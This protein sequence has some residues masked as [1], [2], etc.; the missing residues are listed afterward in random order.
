[1]SDLHIGLVNSIFTI[2]GLFGALL[3]GY[4]AATFGRLRSMR[5][6][7][8]LFILGP[9]A[10]ALAPN[11]IVM[12][13]GRFVSGL[14]AGAALV[15]VPIYIS[16][17]APPSKKG[18]FG[19]FTQ[20]ATNVGIF[21]A[22]LLGLFLSRGQLWRI[23]LAVGG[24]FG[25]LQLGGLSLAV[26]SP[27]W[28]AEHGQASQAKKDLRKIRG[29]EYDVTSEVNGWHLET[30]D[31]REEEG[32]AL[33]QGEDVNTVQNEQ[34]RKR[35]VA[36]KETLGIFQVILH[37]QY[38]R[39]IFAVMMVMIAQQFCGINSIVIYGVTLLS[40]L[41]AASA[42]LLNVFVAIINLAVT[43][44]C[45][46]LIDK[47]GR[48]A[49]LLMS[50]VGMGSTSLL[51]AIAIIKSVPALSVIAVL[52]FVAS[53]GLGL[54]PVPFILSSELV[55]P[56]AVGA[57]QSWALAAN[58]ISTFIV[59]FFFPILNRAL[60]KGK[61]YFVFT[62]F[63]AF[64]AAFTAWWVPETMGK[65]DAEEVWGRQANRDRADQ[66]E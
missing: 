36:K 56:E 55:G 13:I 46:P 59:S 64:F 66:D 58:W 2:G 34:P 21:S 1:M 63:A 31:E 53:F 24:F 29:S 37:P 42:G 10:E 20:V 45:A 6:N 27:K 60:G 23:I 28:V 40:D 7:D 52:G 26:E 57:A 15:I 9:L 47:A 18:F 62:A 17:I 65:R 48:K 41:L 25:L 14:G 33:L 4:G 44:I 30:S 8:V 22:Q 43:L 49:C 16:E 5:Y 35:D 51:L 11:V 3:A 12:A 39:A 50:M 32:T 38:H 61:V 19:A 54:G